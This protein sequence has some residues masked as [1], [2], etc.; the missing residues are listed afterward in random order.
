[1]KLKSIFA[2]KI[3]SV[4]YDGDHECSFDKVFNEWFDAEYLFDFLESHKVLIEN[5]ETWGRYTLEEL[6]EMIQDEADSFL[7]RLEEENDFDNEFHILSKNCYEINLVKSKAYGKTIDEKPSLLRLYAIKIDVNK[8]VITGGAIKFVRAMQEQE[9][10]RVELNR[11]QF[12]AH[13]L[14]NNGVEISKEIEP[15]IEE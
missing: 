15:L 7:E 6:V 11:L 1:M 13:W 2:N 10:L 8:Y 3:W 9:E 12:V 4:L 5:S 14:K